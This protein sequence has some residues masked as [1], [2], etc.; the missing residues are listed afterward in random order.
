[1]L[2]P[3]LAVSQ[4][5]SL[6]ANLSSSSYYKAGAIQTFD[7]SFNLQSQDNEFCDSLA[8]TFPAGV[9]I[10]QAP[11]QFTYKQGSQQPAELLRLSSVG[12]HILSYGDNDNIKGGIETGSYHF[13]IQVLFPSNLVGQ[14]K[15]HWYISGDE[16]G[17]A[18]HEFQDSTSVSPLPQQPDLSIATSLQYPF[19]SAPESMF[20]TLR[21][22]AQI[23]NRGNS[24]STSNQIL[25]NHVEQS[26]LVSETF[27][28]NLGF[29][30]IDTYT[31]PEPFD[32]TIGIQT[33][34][35]QL[36]ET[37]DFDLTNNRDTLQ[38]EVTDTVY[39]VTYPKNLAPLP[40]YIDVDAIGQIMAFP[41]K[42]TLTSLTVHMLSPA[43]GDALA[44]EVFEWTNNE[45]G[46]FLFRSN[47]ITVPTSF[48]GFY[49]FKLPD[50]EFAANDSFFIALDLTQ[51]PNSLPAMGKASFLQPSDRF[52]IQNEWIPSDSLLIF[53]HLNV[54]YNVGDVA[55]YCQ[56]SFDYTYQSG[57]DILFESNT[58]QFTYNWS[59]NGLTSG[60][61]NTFLFE[62]PAEG[63][64]E[65]CLQSTDSSC[66]SSYCEQV[67]VQFN[68]TPESNFS[69]GINLF[70][71]PAA[72]QI[73]IESSAA[74]PVYRLAIFD[75]TGKK[76]YGKVINTQQT[77]C[78]ISSLSPG[79]YVVQ[80]FSEK[81]SVY[82]KR[83]ILTR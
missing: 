48:P 8:I 64:Y 35:V 83:L 7:F 38:I 47:E 3:L 2:F 45:V 50:L 6:S 39:A 25:V 49:N 57:L 61:G 26:N 21:L 31:F 59:V 9:Q 30:E 18:P 22:V 17:S 80:I 44:V 72:D 10:I 73:T 79:V 74:I 33:F 81:S 78:D 34:R 13:H 55:P 29:Q 42:D 60:V 32:V 68:G 54:L 46:S 69:H 1:M 20:D 16:N 63:I 51:A 40:H 43:Q 41:E 66:T 23:E 28:F 12:T 11:H 65:V 53:N 5:R 52:F 58:T 24:Y 19:S 70:P 76:V 15:L 67:N 4:F 37:T 36:F 75:A 71:N 82:T 56:S 27:G 14:Q 62:F 77:S